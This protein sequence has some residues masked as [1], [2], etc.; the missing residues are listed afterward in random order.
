MRHLILIGLA[1]AGLSLRA[2]CFIDGAYVPRC[3]PAKPVAFEGVSWPV[4]TADSPVEVLE[5]LDQTCFD[6]MEITER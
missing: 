3:T 4:F 5:E 2:E 1:L 6:P